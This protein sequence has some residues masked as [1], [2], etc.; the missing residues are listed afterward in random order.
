[1]GNKLFG[2]DIA[3]LIETNVGPG[4][5]PATVTRQVKGTRGASLTAAIPV[6]TQTFTCRGVWDDYTYSRF[7]AD[8][9]IISGDK[10]ALLIGLKTVPRK[11]DVITIAG[12]SL[13]VVRIDSADPAGATYQ[14]QCRDRA[15]QS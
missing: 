4:L 7:S 12:V 2:V 9:E 13:V 1:M 6:T 15:S 3:K 11:E 10:K 14:V 5:L 8:N